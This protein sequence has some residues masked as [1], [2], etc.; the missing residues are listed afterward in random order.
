MQ[1]CAE[2]AGTAQITAPPADEVVT[3]LPVHAVRIEEIGVLEQRIELDRF[4][5]GKLVRDGGDQPGLPA[6]AAVPGRL[7]DERELIG[8]SLDRALARKD[9]AEQGPGK[10]A[11]V[12]GHG[13]GFQRL[14]IARTAIF[15]PCSSTVREGGLAENAGI[16]EKGA[17]RKPVLSEIL[18]PEFVG[19]AQPDPLAQFVVFGEILAIYSRRDIPGASEVGRELAAG[20]REIAPFV[21]Q[22]EILK[23]QSFV[24]EIPVFARLRIPHRLENA[25]RGQRKPLREVHDQGRLDLRKKIV[26]LV[27]RIVGFVGPVVLNLERRVG[28]DERR[29]AVIGH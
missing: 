4:P 20:H 26:Q 22:E 7:T 21:V 6:V 24:L 17:R 3:V 10:V 28:F 29:F 1:H 14:R 25:V 23:E 16:E 18:E 8:Q 11:A 13:E 9:V 5:N 2:T 15:N 19:R 27:I 12:E